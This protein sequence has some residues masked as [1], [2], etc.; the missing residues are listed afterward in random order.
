M[1]RAAAFMHGYR[2]NPSRSIPSQS[3]LVS[4]MAAVAILPAF[5]DPAYRYAA[6]K[7]LAWV[8]IEGIDARDRGDG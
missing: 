2:S 7:A 4:I 1:I 5:R 6:A 3:F 8:T